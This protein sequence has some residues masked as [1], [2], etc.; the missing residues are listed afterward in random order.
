[1]EE[2]C[3]ENRNFTGTSTNK[4]RFV[5]CKK[6][7]LIP[8]W[9]HRWASF[10]RAIQKLGCAAELLRCHFSTEKYINFMSMIKKRNVNILIL[11][12][13]KWITWRNIDET[14][15]SIEKKIIPFALW[16]QAEGSIWVFPFDIPRQSDR[17]PV[18]THQV[19][20][21]CRTAP[22]VRPRCT[23]RAVEHRLDRVSSRGSKVIIFFFYKSRRSKRGI[24][25][26]QI[27][28]SAV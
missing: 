22:P 7:N 27:G 8:F 13:K 12:L 15:D 28:S 11:A 19:R 1:M 21:K 4:Y 10:V 25:W 16:H 26:S 9:S 24:T 20:H 2:Y 18:R 5:S 14:L 6:I 23:A 17:P 3:L